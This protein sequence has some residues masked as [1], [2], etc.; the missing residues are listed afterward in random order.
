MKTRVSHYRI[1]IPEKYDQPEKAFHAVFLSDQHDRDVLKDGR[2]METLCEADPAAVFC[3]GDMLNAGGAD[4]GHAKNALRLY[5]ALSARFKVYAV[6]GNH[7]GRLKAHPSDYLIDYNDYAHELESMGVTLL[8]GR[9]EEIRPGGARME[10]AGF[11]LPLSSYNRMHP[12]MPGSGELRRA[13]GEKNR[14][15]FTILLAHHPDGFPSYREWGADL[16]LSGH[17]HGGLIVLPHFG[18]MAGGSLK[19]FPKYCRGSF[20]EGTSRMIVSAGIGEH[21]K[22]L[23][24]NNPY[25]ITVLEFLQRDKRPS[26]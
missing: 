26:S 10:I 12:V 4:R 21:T 9:R 25:E 15:A 16:V 11:E 22:A 23:R 3:G 5:E 18:G 13:L 8:G 14:E 19:P 6:D 1:R 24:I 20:E 2:F 17:F 7:E